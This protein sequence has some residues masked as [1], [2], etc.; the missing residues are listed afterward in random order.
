LL[1]DL[2]NCTVMLSCSRRAA[3]NFAMRLNPSN[4]IIRRSLNAM[5][6]V[7]GCSCK[8][9]SISRV[10]HELPPRSH[11]H[12]LQLASGNLGNAACK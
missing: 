1:D 5:S 9:C 3:L 6:A 8:S 10:D 11:Q 4:C 7:Q 2:V 12:G